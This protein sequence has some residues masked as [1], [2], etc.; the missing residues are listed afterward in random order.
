MRVEQS[1]A[2]D[3]MRP[4]RLQ[5]HNRT[6]RETNQKLVL[7]QLENQQN[8][9][10]ERGSTRSQREDAHMC[11]IQSPESKDKKFIKGRQLTGDLSVEVSSS[12]KSSVKVLTKKRESNI[13]LSTFA[14]SSESSSPSLA[15]S[16]LS[17]MSMLCSKES[18]SSSSVC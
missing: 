18:E 5:S 15:D 1:E 8:S 3:R 16:R 10:P 13:L 11:R 6:L 2:S 9:S 7:S 17:S 12:L 4:M 14:T